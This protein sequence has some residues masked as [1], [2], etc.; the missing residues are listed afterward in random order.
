MTHPN[1]DLLQRGYEAFGTGDMDTVLGIFAD[2][3]AWHV[4]GTSRISGDYRGHAEVMAF[5]GRLFELSDG[6]LRL[7][8]HDIL[9]NDEH[10]VVLITTHAQ[11]ATGTLADR[12]VHVWHLA[13]GKATEFWG[14]AED[15][16][17]EDVFF[18]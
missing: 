17:R 8:V 6:T 15:Q 11:N 7:D 4:S 16:A 5:F 2:D 3:I 14:F 13:N 10:G 9:A 18:G 1:V 12:Q